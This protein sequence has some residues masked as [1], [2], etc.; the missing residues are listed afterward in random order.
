M[1]LYILH[2]HAGL[3]PQSPPHIYTYL[4]SHEIILS[5][6]FDNLLSLCSISQIPL[7]FNIFLDVIKWLHD[8]LLQLSLGIHRKLVP[9]HLPVWPDTQICGCSSPLCMKWHSIMVPLYRSWLNLQIQRT[10]CKQ[11][12]HNLISP[13]LLNIVTPKF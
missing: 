7:H 9:G 11:V 6:L 2:K 1:N 12:Y 5:I 4:L 10:V 13:L 3:Y 8:I